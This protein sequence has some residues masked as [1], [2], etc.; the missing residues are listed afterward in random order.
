MASNDYYKLLGVS[1]DAT[2]SE[3]KKAY[4][5]L[6]LKYHPDQNKGNPAAEE[7]FKQINEAYAVL[8]DKK[9][10]A[11]YDKFGS[12]E[13]HQRYSQE[14]IFKGFNI[15]DIF[16]N[17]FGQQFGRRTSGSGN[18]FENFGNFNFGG[19]GRSS[20][21][22]DTDFVHTRA[23]QKKKGEDI[24]H[25]LII[26]IEEAAKGS[27]KNITL[28]YGASQ[29]KKVKIDIP[30]GIREGQKLR[31]P[32]Q[33]MP[34]LHGGPKGDLLL[35]I[36]MS[37]HHLFRR[38][39]DD[40]YIEKE[41]TIAQA[42]LGCTINV[43]TL[44]GSKNLKIKP[45]IQSHTLMRLKGYGM[46]KMNSTDKGNLYVKIIV[47]TPTNLNDEQVRLFEALQKTGRL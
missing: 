4:R 32:G 2:D 44:D 46:P 42:V 25:D 20:S 35:H 5:K 24:T 14:D 22:W 38:E 27:K 10:R 23:P 16:E 17:L 28:R 15:N 21:G 3:L 39:D 34:G 29:T 41:I 11:Q 6:A 8:S 45:G 12:A 40:L 1:K 26:S 31:I 47:R 19:G 33:G 7:K 30:M 36:K 37:P 43:Q 9:K 18:P 13:F